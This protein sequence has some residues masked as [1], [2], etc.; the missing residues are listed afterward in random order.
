MLSLTKLHLRFRDF[1]RFLNV[2]WFNH[3]IFYEA[4][5]IMTFSTVHA[6]R[7]LRDLGYFALFALKETQSRGGKRGKSMQGFID[8]YSYGHNSRYIQN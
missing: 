2:V 3:S 5:S 8:V 6:L 4:E 7:S 1:L